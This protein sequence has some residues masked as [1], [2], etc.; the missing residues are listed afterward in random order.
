MRTRSWAAIIMVGVM[1]SSGG[2]AVPSAKAVPG[3]GPEGDGAVPPIYSNRAYP[4][5]E[6]AVDLVSRMTL[7]EK[8]AQMVSSQ[9]AALPRL[10]IAA[11]GWWNEAAHGVA[12]EG[13][14]HN[15][16]PPILTNT[17]S[18]PV[19]LSLGATWNPDLVYREATLISDEAREVVRDNRLDLNFY[20]PTINLARDPRWGRNDEA[21]SE[22]PLLTAALAAQFVNGMEGKDRAGRL[23]P[24]GGGYLKTSTTLKHYAANNSEFD[25]ITG[26]ANM[27]DRT[28]REYYTAQFREVIRRSSPASI[29]TSY[30][31]VN[32][33][34]T[35]ASGYLMDELARQTFGFGGF[36]TSDCDS[37]REI[38]HGHHWQPP[39]EPEPLDHIERHAWANAAGEDLNC[40]QGYHDQW[41][42][43]NTIPEAVAR[44]ID[45]PNG[46]YTEEHVDA[47]LVRLLTTRI[48][49]GEFDP[50]ENVPWVTAARSRVA[51]GTWTNSDANGAVTQTAD[52]LALAREV[53]AES[54][55][56]LKNEATR[57]VATD[58]AG[59]RHGGRNALLPLRV[60]ASGAYRVAVIGHYANPP[61]MY[62]G[63]YSS[64]QASAGQANEVNGYAGVR[65]AIRAINP[66]AVVDHLPG[67]TPGTLAEVD[68]AS[69]A[70]AASYDAVIVYAGTDDRHS[71][72]DV[73][74]RTLALPGAQASLISQVA[75]R[76]PNTV[77]YL[78]TAGQVDVADFEAAVPALLWSSYNGQRK[79]EALADVLLGKRNP[80]GRLPF[81]WYR[82]VGQLP[83]IDDYGI[84]GDGSRPGRTYMYFDG[85]VSYPFGHG[86]GYTGF[87]YSRPS[88]D[89]SRVDANGSVRVSVDVT[90]TGSVA[91]SEVVQLYVGT[92]TAPA[93]RQR[94]DKRLNGFQKISLR[95]K[96]TKRVRFTVD[97]PDLAF[98]DDQLGRYVVD[99]GAYLIQVGRSSADTGP[100]QQVRVLVGGSLRPELSVITATAPTLLPRNAVVSP[101]VTIA[102]SDDTRY[103]YRAE[104]A[105]TPLP[106]GT[107]VR[108]RSNRPGVV[109]V[110]PAGVIRTGVPGVATITATVSYRGVSRS[111]EFSLGV[112]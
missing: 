57:P 56:L 111:T 88:V 15:A 20:S 10:G 40:Q 73:D 77:V 19:D 101:R 47:A 103:G 18:Y 76:N 106:A 32:G 72:E 35:S 37:I 92:P 83:P 85:E 54:I 95:P 21:F 74:R 51:P 81:T 55:V 7:E 59:N 62:L 104:G 27:D 46:R 66:G 34:P 86:L 71:R 26:S 78:E 45:T 49:L 5:R 84:R 22:D 93:A 69:V 58:A 24:Q 80:S 25:R 109:S 48:Q 11:Y 33:V 36:F 97:V 112:R 108:Y 65:A 90:N 75:A 28:L 64:I 13:T 67:V 50:A 44:G 110:D 1:V 89:R 30:N 17:T 60:P 8:A 91:G 99:R 94:P 98:F 6:R 107:I 23:L 68:P 70:A 41:S 79:G 63:G 42:Y 39:G 38:Q 53:G 29:M 96:Q 14:L 100:R 16:N 105:S 31:R 52:R 87:A 2:S 3:S 12:R 61:S 9:S 43:A 4:A 102:M 82:D